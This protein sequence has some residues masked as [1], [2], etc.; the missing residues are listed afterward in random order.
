M[1][2]LRLIAWQKDSAMPADRLRRDRAAGQLGAETAGLDRL[3]RI[4][5]IRWP[6][7]DGQS[8]ASIQMS[9]MKVLKSGAARERCNELSRAVTQ[10]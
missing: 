10:V 9:S 1:W 2:T 4:A 8:D 3:G 5:T 7:P 6:N